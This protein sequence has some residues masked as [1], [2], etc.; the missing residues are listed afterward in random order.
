ME[1][2]LD[3]ETVMVLADIA[4]HYSTSITNVR[5]CIHV[6]CAS[7][8]HPSELIRILSE[9]ISTL[10]VYETTIT[11]KYSDKALVV[12]TQSPHTYQLLSDAGGMYNA[13]L[14]GGAGFIFPLK[15]LWLVKKC[16]R[17]DCAPKSQPQ[18]RADAPPS[19]S[20]SNKA[21]TISVYS[22][23]ALVLRNSDGGQITKEQIA[24]FKKIG[25]LW[26]PKLKQGGPGV[27]FGKNAKSI[28]KLDEFLETSSGGG[29]IPAKEWETLFLK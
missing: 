23:H 22:D 20:I 27:I 12:R 21:Y 8:L 3:L 2:E 26:N 16:A 15:M 11:K 14:K 19:V 9:H 28:K 25:G 17:G 7:T 1:E 29:K 5:K 4:K 10:D 13:R 24:Q 18:P 6:A